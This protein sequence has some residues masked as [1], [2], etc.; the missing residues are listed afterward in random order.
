MKKFLLYLIIFLVNSC[1]QKSENKFGEMYEIA[2]YFLDSIYNDVDLVVLK[3][4]PNQINYKN[5]LSDNLSDLPPPQDPPALTPLPPPV[6]VDDSYNKDYFKSYYQLKYIDAVDVDYMYN[7]VNVKE[8]YVLDS[9]RIDRKVIMQIDKKFL[10]KRY[11]T[12]EINKILADKLYAHKYIEFCVPLI[13]KD[14]KKVIIRVNSYCGNLC[15]SSAI[16]LL[17]KL[18]GKWVVK[19]CDYIWK[20]SQEYNII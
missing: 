13:S 17:V 16:F 20:S 10:V 19:F 14:N 15:G 3:L 8:T 18:D 2:E 5:Y 12:D 9:T 6:P 4:Q 11:G 7:Q 1:I